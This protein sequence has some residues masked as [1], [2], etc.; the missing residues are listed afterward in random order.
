MKIST[1]LLTTLLMFVTTLSAIAQTPEQIQKILSKYDLNNL[2]LLEAQAAFEFNRDRQEALDLAA[3]YGWAESYETENGG[4]GLLVGVLDGNYPLYYETTNKGAGITARVDRVH[5]GGTAG[6]DLN[7][8]NM[9]VG[10]WDGGLVRTT[11]ELLENRVTPIDGATTFSDHSTHVSGTI[12]GSEAFQAGNAKGMA[13]LAEIISSD[14]NNASSEALNAVATYGLLVSNHSYG[15]PADQSPVWFLGKYDSNARLWDQITFSAPYYLPVYSAGNARNTNHPNQADGGYDILTAYSNSKNVLVVAATFQVLNYVNATSVNMSSFSSWGPTDDGRIKPDISAKG[16]NTF[17]SVGPGNSNYANFSGTSMSAP[18]VAGAAILLQQHYSN[19]NAGEFMLSSTLRGLII[20]TADEAGAAPGPDYRFG[21]GLINTERAAAVLTNNGTTT[22]VQEL[23]LPQANVFTLTGTAIP[24][25][26][27]VASI[28][29]TDKQG[30]VTAGQ[31]EDD[32][33]PMLVNDLDLRVTDANN[34][35]YLPWILDHTN[36]SAP[37][38]NGDNFRDNVEK[39]EIDNPVGDYTITISHK[40]VLL[41]DQQVVSLILTGIENVVLSTPDN[42]LAVA[43]IYPNPAS[44]KLNIKAKTQISNVEILNLLG[45][46]M[47]SY[48]VNSNDAQ[49]DIAS[50]SAGTYFVRVTIDNASKVYKFIKK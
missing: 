44:D 16:V 24:G 34:V 14:F 25:E 7:G 43:S 26:R 13:P 2:R 10:V 30:N 37:A 3:I 11:H 18:S 39:I 6:L 4:Q 40:G 1:L 50:L 49:I 27:L 19:L 48:K 23:T 47:G 35:E 41:N 38:T 29:W 42:E 33:T 46:A 21:W 17:S 36:F 8:E 15:I 32:D 5:T 12:L 20:H 45:Q 28:T 22:T 31:I 9:L